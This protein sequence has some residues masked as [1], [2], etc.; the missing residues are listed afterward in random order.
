MLFRDVS[1]LRSEPNRGE[2]VSKVRIHSTEWTGYRKP[3]A[4]APYFLEPMT[5]ARLTASLPCPVLFLRH[6]DHVQGVP[7]E[8]RSLL[9]GGKAT[10]ETSYWFSS[11]APAP[12]VPLS[13]G[14]ALSGPGYL[15]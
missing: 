2:K 1:V 15:L 4:R 6:V 14:S 7:E 13:S 9:T 10:V 3:W 5:S 11:S 8:T 12:S